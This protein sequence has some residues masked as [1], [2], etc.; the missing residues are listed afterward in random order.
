[1]TSAALFVKYAG[2]SR[3]WQSP[4]ARDISID[5]GPCIHLV[6]C[7]SALSVAVGTFSNRGST[8]EAMSYIPNT[9]KA[10]SR[11]LQGRLL[12]QHDCCGNGCSYLAPALQC[13]SEPAGCSG[14]P[15][16]CKVSTVF[17]RPMMKPDV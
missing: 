5:D 7:M 13:R 6:S 15:D 9:I 2:S 12:S 16:Y 4:Q 3:R 1:M 8:S 17:S 14:S 10:Q 11:L